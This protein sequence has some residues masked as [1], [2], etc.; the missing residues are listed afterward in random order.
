MKK[1]PIIFAFFYT[2]FLCA[3]YIYSE[4]PSN[5]IPPKLNDIPVA[6]EVMNFPKENDPVKI[7][8]SYYWKHQTSLV[9][10]ISSVKII[11]YGAYLFYN[12]KWNLRQTYN[13]KTFDKNFETKNETLQIGHPYIWKSNWRVGKDLYGGW[14][15]WY[16]IGINDH[17]IK[18]CGYG[19]IYTT[20]NVLN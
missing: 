19:T 13:I 4:P 16:F 9:S 11:E 3:Q 15:L 8:D 2:G 10:K 12:N 5:S 7:G 18:V 20:D 1:Y 17:G 14:A 6:I